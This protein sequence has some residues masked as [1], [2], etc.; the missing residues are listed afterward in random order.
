[1][2][3]LAVVSG[4]GGTGKTT[5]TAA[6]ADLACRDLDLVMADC[7]VDAANLELLF[8]PEVQETVPYYGMTCAAIDPGVCISCGAC[9]EHCRF[10]AVLAENAIYRVE[11][12]DCEG[13][14][15]CEQV[16]PAGAVRFVE[17]KNGE[18]YSSMTGIGPL[19][20]A[21]LIPGSGTSGLLVTAVKERA[22]QEA[23]GRDLLL[24]DGPPGIGCPLIATVTGCDAVLIIT[25]PSMA[26]RSDLERLVRVCK[27]FRI[28]MFL[29][30]N[31]SD[32]EEG[33]TGEILAF[34]AAGGITVAGLIPFDKAVQHA[35]CSHL[36]VTR[37]P[38]PASD[39]IAGIWTLIKREME[40]P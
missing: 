32:L 12:A 27:G 14:G 9:A 8:S 28:R 23:A 38:S 31:R 6:L 40:L 33:I 11:P 15:V 3:R 24:I 10:D 13:C 39:A 1:M 25:E 16:C 19:F 35:V 7:D 18:I 2:K 21:R 34:C 4:K 26:G 22:L 29:A 17:R 20:H 5:V 30:V 36:P 37:M